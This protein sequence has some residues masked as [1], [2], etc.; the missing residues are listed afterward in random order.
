MCKRKIMGSLLLFT[1]LVFAGQI[2]MAQGYRIQVNLENYSKNTLYLAYRLGT[3]TYV[4]DTVTGKNPEGYFVFEGA[5]PRHPGIYLVVTADDNNTFEFLLPNKKDQ[6]FTLTASA[7]KNM[8]ENWSV[9][10]SRENED[11][12]SYQAFVRKKKQE[13]EKIKG[14]NK[15]AEEAAIQASKSAWEKAY[16]KNNPGKLLSSILKANLEIDIPDAV[17]K[18][19]KNAGFYYYRKHYWD[20]IDLGDNRL[21]YSALLA[22]KV[23][24][25]TE[26]LTVQHPDSLIQAVDGIMSRV[27]KA[28][29]PEVYQSVLIQLFNK[30]AA[31]KIICMDKVYLHMA[32]VYYCGKTSPPWMQQ[33]ELD[34]ICNKLE[35][36]RSSACGATAADINLPEVNN[37]NRISLTGIKSD[38]L[39]VFFW[40][41]DARASEDEFV[42]LQQVYDKW[43]KKGLEVLAVSTGTLA[44]T[45]SFVEKKPAT[46]K[47]VL[48]EDNIQLKKLQADYNITRYPTLYLLDKNK[49]IL[50]K[51]F[52][53]SQLDEIMAGLIK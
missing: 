40:T 15:A 9:S 20:H 21:L 49:K 27:K 41:N 5:E 14:Q 50:Y 24:N 8:S 25:Y 3:K 47:N 45:R 1:C 13:F 2:L 10:G 53:V 43:N 23:E 26:K 52:S 34:R 36:I 42:K 51:K 6:Q 16:I 48:V 12:I 35:N 31:S 4:A 44:K 38:Y 22:E 29:D 46:W 19:G 32:T 18:T 7:G 33:E 28:G 30:Y 39:L 17:Q 37:T 11:L